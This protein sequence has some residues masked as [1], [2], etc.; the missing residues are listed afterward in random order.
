MTLVLSNTTIEPLLIFYK[1]LVR[2]SMRLQQISTF[3]IQQLAKF[4]SVSLTKNVLDHIE[5]WITRVSNSIKD[6]I[7][8]N[9]TKVLDKIQN[10]QIKQ[11]VT[12]FIASLCSGATTTNKE[13][14]KRKLT[15]EQFDQWGQ[16]SLSIVSSSGL[17]NKKP[18]IQS[19]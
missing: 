1:R 2:D 4:S 8:F 18:K 14:R 12:E 5:D 11:K 15:N 17:P 3:L 7:I 6:E 9:S 13:K 19:S 16:L 10:D